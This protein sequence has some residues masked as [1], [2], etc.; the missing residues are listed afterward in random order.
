MLSSSQIKSMR[1]GGHKLAAIRD[2]LVAFT[3][4]GVNL[5]AIDDLAQE[6]IAQSGGKPGFMLVPGYRWA[7]C[8]NIN[9]GIVHGIPHAHITIKSGNIVTL[10]VGLFYQGFHTDTSTSF[11]AG[12]STP[13]Q[14]L[15][16]TT[17][18]KAL[19]DAIS[20]A[21]P[22]HH[23]GHISQ[24]IEQVITSAGYSPLRTLTGHGVGLA[25][26]QPPSIPCFLEGSLEATAPIV[27]GMTL[28]IE[29]IYAAG[30]F[31]TKKL[32][33]GWTIV[34]AD[35]QPSAVF[36]DTILITHQQPEI[37]THT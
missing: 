14:R 27:P 30:S 16:L 31:A 23:I 8:I 2:Q 7:T 20:Q 1:L 17:G 32:S 11:V 10:D 26:H 19:L 6:L 18:K 5:K 34:T 36:E 9:D 3:V 33:D 12:V 4:P 21:R 35:G 25:L 24:A 15:F 29:A 22:G 13:S 37:L 28:A